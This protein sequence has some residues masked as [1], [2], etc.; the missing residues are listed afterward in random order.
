MSRVFFCALAVA[1]AAGM[2]PGGVHAAG[3]SQPAAERSTATA[4]SGPRE[5]R[6][7]AGGA[8]QPAVGSMSPERVR[9]DAGRVNPVPAGTPDTQPSLPPGVT[10]TAPSGEPA[11]RGG[12]R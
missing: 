6:G 5:Q 10:P 3:Q 1:V 12:G 9:E 2:A 7:V 4:D 8:R 11:M